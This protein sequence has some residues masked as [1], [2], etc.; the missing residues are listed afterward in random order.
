ME[1][2]VIAGDVVK[3]HN[4]E[5]GRAVCTPGLRAVPTDGHAAG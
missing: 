1:V 2:A 5:N 3:A 4:K